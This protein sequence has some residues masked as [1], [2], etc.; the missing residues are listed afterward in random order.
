MA[1]YNCACFKI[2]ATDP[3]AISSESL[4]LVMLIK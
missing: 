2:L 4:W 3:L 1:I